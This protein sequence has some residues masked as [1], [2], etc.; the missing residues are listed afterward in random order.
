M[1]RIVK[2]AAIGICVGLFLVIIKEGFQIDGAAFW[3]AYWI[4]APIIVA[5]A[6]MINVF[7]NISYQNRVKKIAKLLDEEKPQEYGQ[8]DKAMALYHESQALF[9]KYRNG[10]IYGANIAVLDILA[11]INKEQYVQAERLLAV[12]RET[13]QGVR[14]QKAFHEIAQRLSEIKNSQ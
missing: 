5:G 13:Y 7:Y 8:S 10:K 6:V 4:L 3:R 9:Q 11:A 14:F 1:R 2:I 12:A